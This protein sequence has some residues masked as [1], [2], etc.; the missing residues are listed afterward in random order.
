MILIFFIFLAGMNIQSKKDGSFEDKAKQQVEDKAKQ[1]AEKEWLNF[2]KLYPK[3][4]II[5]DKKTGFAQKVNKFATEI[6]PGKPEERATKFFGQHYQLFGMKRELVGLEYVKTS[7]VRIEGKKGIDYVRFRQVYNKLPVVGTETVVHITE[8]GKVFKVY[9]RFYSDIKLANKQVLD[10]KAAIRIARKKIKK[11]NLLPVE[12]K[13]QLVIY[14]LKD[15]FYIAWEIQIDY[16]RFYVDGEKGTILFSTNTILFQQT[17]SGQVYSE[18]SCDTPNRINGSLPNLD[19][20]GYLRG[21]FFD[22]QADNRALENSLAFNYNV[23]NERFDQVEIYYQFERARTYFGNLGFTPNPQQTVAYA[24]EDLFLY[25]CNAAYNWANNY[26]IFGD[27]SDGGGCSPVCNSPGQD[28]DIIFHEYTHQVI[29]QVSGIDA[30][31]HW[32]QSIHEGVADYFSCSFFDDPQLAEPLQGGCST[33]LR[34]IS[35]DK[36]YPD[37]ADWNDPHKMGLIL[38]SALWDIRQ[39]LGQQLADWAIYNGLL[40]LPANADFSDFAQSVLDVIAAKIDDIDNWVVKLILILA[41]IDANDNF[42]NHGI[43]AYECSD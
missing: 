21:T 32:P 18:N 5:W 11:K 34:N 37:N 33:A 15:K 1:Q 19:G 41:L 39:D 4:R 10:K 17:G 31:Q 43:E 14:P 2:K 42:C 20:S 38:G 23:S 26:F 9:N 36:K 29:H 30:S 7:H 40:G 3:S 8:T 25:I 13:G 6:I 35:I 22:V 12:D 24:N 27:K 16:K 28:G